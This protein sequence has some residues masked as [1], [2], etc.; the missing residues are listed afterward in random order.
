MIDLVEERRVS[1]NRIE[2]NVAVAGRAS[3]PLVILLHGFPELWYAWRK[4]IPFLAERGY[5][6]WAPDQRGYNTSDKP[7]G[8]AQYG[9]DVLADDVVGL[10]DAAGRDQAILIGH[11]WGAAVAWRVAQQFPQRVTQLMI[12][13]GPHPKA[14]HRILRSDLRQLL[15]SWYMFFFQLPGIERILLAQGAA[16]LVSKLRRTSHPSTFDDQQLGIYRRSWEEPGAMR[17]MLDWYRAAFRVRARPARHS[18]VLPPTLVLWG[19]RDPFVGIEA[20]KRSVALCEQGRLVVLD[21]GTHWIH[22]EESERVNAMML[23]FLES[24]SAGA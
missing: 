19:A 2:L 10:I 23:S 15:M 22:I 21:E 3:G 20:A 6:V 7:V 14:M 18:R 13:S 9:I 24:G 1:T 11:D 5:W 12:L 4:Q 8:L 16:R 17:A